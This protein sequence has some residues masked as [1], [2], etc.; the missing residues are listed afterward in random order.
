MTPGELSPIRQ[1]YEAKTGSY[2]RATI[3]GRVVTAMVTPVDEEGLNGE[4]ITSLVEHLEGSGSEGL[5]I[6]GTTGE[7]TAL[8]FGEHL[9]LLRIVEESG[10]LPVLAATGSINVREAIK[11]SA[12]VTEQE[13][14]DGLLVIPPPYVRPTQESILDYFRRIREVSDLPIVLYNIPIRIG[15]NVE[16]ETILAMAEA[17]YIDGI[18]DAQSST[19]PTK[20]LLLEAP[21][22][23]EVFSG[24]DS[25]NLELFRAGAVGAISVASHWAGR[26]IAA[27]FDAVELGDERRAETINERLEASYDFESPDTARNPAPTKAMMRVILG[28]EIGYPRPPMNV[29]SIIN[30]GLEAMAISIRKD[31]EGV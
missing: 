26:E 10:E 6:A 20:D 21:E 22:G 27:M 7:G 9:D 23:F 16:V 4:A 13:L 12:A 15:V 5:V 17:G 19:V 3:A 25:F 29:N 24:N 31:L 14:A 11:L 28:P 18:K 8:S 2:E 1:A 30:V